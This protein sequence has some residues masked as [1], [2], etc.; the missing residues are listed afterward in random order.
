MA[1]SPAR[2]ALQRGFILVSSLIFLILV[3][4][5][6]LTLLRN[7]LTEQQISVNMSD[8]SYAAALAESALKGGENYAANTAPGAAFTQD[9]AQ[10]LCTPAGGAC[11]VEAWQRG[12]SGCSQAQDGQS[13]FDSAGRCIAYPVASQV[14][15][16]P[17]YIVELL[18]A[19]YPGGGRLYRVTARAWGRNGNTKVTL[20]SVLQVDK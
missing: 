13:V 10:G 19:A 2:N 14:A 1:F 9:C 4:L 16:S 20:Q 15:K 3:A 12:A 7:D 6:A 17:C 11:Q 8:R 5:L 18:Q